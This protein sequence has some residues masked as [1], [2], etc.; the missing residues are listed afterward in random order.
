MDNYIEDARENRVVKNV[1]NLVK[2]QHVN[3]PSRTESTLE[4]S[5]FNLVKSGTGNKGFIRLNDLTNSL[6]QR[7]KHIDVSKQIQNA[8]RK[9]KTLQKPLEKFQTER[10][11]RNV[12][13]GKVTK[14]LDEWEAIVTS[15]RAA[16]SLSFPLNYETKLA[17]EK[18]EKD[19]FR[20]KTDLQKK[21][22]ELEPKVEIYNVDMEL[23]K[24]HPL[25]VAELLEKRREAAK[26]RAHQSYKEAKARRQSKIKSKKYHRIQRK[27]KIKQKMKEFELLQ[28]TNPEAALLK[29][30]EIEKARAEE[31]ASLRHKSTG[32]WARSKQ[33]RAKYDKEV[34]RELFYIKN[35]ESISQMI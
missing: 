23:E 7:S 24:K 8:E 20:L 35:I 34:K 33:V 15:N 3:K 14:H 2:K 9:G 26:L 4:V 16:S 30:E 6:K 28:K 17:D 25:N 1:T 31:R 22:E 29:L 10:I 12:A 27:E 32:Q 11:R 5:E 21:L 18:L 19:H 13:Y